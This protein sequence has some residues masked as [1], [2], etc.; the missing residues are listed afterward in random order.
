MEVDRPVVEIPMTTINCL[1]TALLSLLL[2]LLGAFL[3]LF[4]PEELRWL[5]IPGILLSVV[6]LEGLF[7]L[8]HGRLISPAPAYRYRAQDLKV[9][10]RGPPR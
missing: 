10:F 8:L 2:F 4:H 3:T 6:G 9:I 1:R 5:L 7:S